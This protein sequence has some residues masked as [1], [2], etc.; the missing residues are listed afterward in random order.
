M[1]AK[2]ALGFLITFPIFSACEDP[3]NLG[4]ELDPNNNQ[5]GVF[6]QEIPLTALVIQQDSLITTNPES[7]VFGSDEGDF[8]GKTEATAYSRL[9]FNR[10]LARP[11][12]TATLDS[13]RFNFSIRAVNGNDLSTDKTIQVHRLNEQIREVNYYNFSRLDYEEEPIFSSSFNFS[14][15]QDTLVFATIT[16]N[17]FAIELFEALKEGSAFSDIFTFRNFLPGLV[18]KGGQDENTSFNARPGNNTGFIFFYKNEGD[19]ISR[20]YPIATGVNNNSAR[21]F[22]QIVNDPTGTPTAQITEKFVAYDLGE[23]AGAKNNTGILVKLD[24]SALDA[25]LDTLENVTFNQVTLEMGPLERNVATNRPPQFLQMFF[26]NETNRVL[27]GDLGAFAVQSDGRPQFDPA[28]GDPF[29]GDAPALLAHNRENNIYRQT[30]TSHVNAIYRGNLQRR[31]FILYPLV[32]GTD[33]Y[34]QS[35]R[36]FVLDS[37]SPVLKIFYSKA[38][39][40]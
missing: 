9:L 16:E 13:V 33:E 22:N 8:F 28:T 39:A 37:R 27:L 24:M 7:L 25:F 3:S 1:P 4:L 10:D 29:V 17:A 35:L 23:R 34:R 14:N 18:F 31:D 19:T 12:S 26:T 5:I 30:I 2:L 38:R 32:G 20:A 6:Y 15:R 40:F 21:H 36:E 11:N